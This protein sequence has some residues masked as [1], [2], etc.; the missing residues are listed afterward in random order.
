MW[1]VISGARTPLIWVISTVTQ[2]MTR[3]IT[4]H[5]PP[6]IPLSQPISGLLH[7]RLSFE[8]SDI[9]SGDCGVVRFMAR[10][11]EE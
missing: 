10:R 1:V 6:S 11:V 7:V 5:E 3:L 4:T 9:Y 2:L 8:V